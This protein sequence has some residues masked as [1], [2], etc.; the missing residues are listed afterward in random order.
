[1]KGCDLCKSA[2]ARM[3][4]DSDQASLCWGCDAKVHSANF[5]V[6]RHS[7]TLLCHACQSP[8]PWSAS[9][10]KLGQTVSV[11]E[12]CVDGCGGVKGAEE[13]GVRN[14]EESD[15]GYDG[16][17]EEDDED[18]DE[19]EEGENQVVPWS[20]TPPPPPPD[21]SSSSSEDSSSRFC[22]G[23]RA[24]SLKQLRRNSADLCSD[25]DDHGCSSAHRE[26]RSPAAPRHCGTVF[27]EPLRPLKRQRTDLT[28]TS[29]NSEIME[30]IVEVCSLSENPAAVRS[31]SSRM[32]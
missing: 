18:D 17:E 3:Y 24:A 27:V 20:S 31:E 15:G 25:D 1:M 21:A 23:G 26:N 9:G 12:G 14:D 32:P 30:T 28:G 10:E 29:T 7:R 6:A 19:E 2:A 4:C 13:N 11:C 22:N 5:L 16:E 8:T